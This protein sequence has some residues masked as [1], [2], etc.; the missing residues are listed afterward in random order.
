MPCC[1]GAPG[2]TYVN[3][4]TVTGRGS[5]HIDTASWVSPP[6]AVSG[7]PQATNPS[8][9]PS[10]PF[11]SHVITTPNGPVRTA[12]CSL[13]WS[14][15]GQCLALFAAGLV[16][17]VEHAVQEL[18]VLAEHGLLKRSPPFASSGRRFLPTLRWRA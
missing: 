17:A 6:R 18:G 13:S 9:T 2:D 5:A 7:P 4:P 1:R 16:A 3:R 15:P 10:T 14:R 11:P 8:I 12:R